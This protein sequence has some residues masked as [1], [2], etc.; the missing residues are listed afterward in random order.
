[1]IDVEVVV[2]V[3]DV[4]VEVV[5]ATVEVIVVVVVGDSRSDCIYTSSGHTACICMIDFISMVLALVESICSII[6]FIRTNI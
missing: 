6:L 2:V 1:M 3:I 4:V 5:V